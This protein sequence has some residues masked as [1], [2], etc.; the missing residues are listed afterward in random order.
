MIKFIMTFYERSTGDDWIKKQYFRVVKCNNDIMNKCF[1]F[2]PK[3]TKT[4]FLVMILSSEEKGD[5][6]KKKGDPNTLKPAFIC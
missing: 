6:H 5:G 3:A 1:D 2:A 4:I